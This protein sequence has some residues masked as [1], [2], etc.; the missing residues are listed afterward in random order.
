M[1]NC[2]VF[3]II[4]KSSCDICPGGF[5]CLANISDYS[6]TPCDSGYYCPAGTT[7]PA[8]Y[9][10]PAG[11]YNPDAGQDSSASC[12]DCPAGEYCGVQGLSAPS[13]NC[14]EGWFC[15]GAAFQSMPTVAG[16]YF[17]S[18]CVLIPKGG[19][20]NFYKKFLLSLGIISNKT[21]KLLINSII[22]IFMIYVSIITVLL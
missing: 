14:S 4:G 7:H 20:C 1:S 21:L 15:T 13:G 19:V 6:L 16:Q 18:A 8:Q 5:Y 2:V 11:T 3:F 9:P 12:R 22:T 17:I 10:C